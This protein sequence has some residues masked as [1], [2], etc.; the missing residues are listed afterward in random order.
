[1]KI[2]LV[3]DTHGHAARLRLALALLAQQGA[4]AVV[5]CG[6][7]DSVECLELLGQFQWTAHAV[8]GNVDRHLSPRLADAARSAAV[9]FSPRTVEVE[10]QPGRY[11][12]ATHG[13][14]RDL[15]AELIAGGQFAYVCHGHT[16]EQRDQRLGGVRVI[17]PGAL[18]R[19]AQH[20]VALLD[21]DP[22]TVTFIPIG[23]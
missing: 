5:H 15:L 23:D 13:H 1:M 12:V 20:T 19:A 3:S 6:D 18:Y 7:L 22:D 8:A 14:D 10:Y 9:H 21:T 17:N 4:E 16:H 11:L 2:G